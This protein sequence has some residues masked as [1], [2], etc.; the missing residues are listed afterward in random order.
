MGLESVTFIS[1]LV[2]TNPVSTDLKSAGDDHIR[3]IKSALLNTFPLV[4][5]AVSVTHMELNALVGVTDFVQDQLDELTSTKTDVGHTHTAS[6]I[7]TGVIAVEFGGTGIEFATASTFIM[8]D[9]A[10]PFIPTAAVTAVQTMLNGLSP[11]TGSIITYDGSEWDLLPQGVS[12]QLLQSSGADSPPIWAASSGIETSYF[13]RH[14]PRMVGYPGSGT[15]FNYFAFP[16]LTASGTASAVANDGTTYYATRGGVK[17]TTAASLNAMAG[18][19]VNTD[20]GCKDGVRLAIRFATSGNAVSWFVGLTSNTSIPAGTVNPRT[21][22]SGYAGVGYDYDQ[23]I[24]YAVTVDGDTQSLSNFQGFTELSLD[25]TI[26]G[27]DLT[28]YLY[29]IPSNGIGIIPH[30]CSINE[31]GA[32]TAATR[33]LIWCSSRAASAAFIQLNSIYLETLY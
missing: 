9:G 23:D 13:L 18:F 4:T 14:V 20:V 22:G 33:P 29:E 17:V 10:N 21:A 8:G 26:I 28:G 5:G 19:F 16:T 32:A 15:S 3:R 6:D 24:L 7:S 2:S 30:A 12:G 27:N 11:T 31:T 1:D 25:I